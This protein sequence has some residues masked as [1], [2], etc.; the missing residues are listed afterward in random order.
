MPPTA[1]NT[2]R[3]RV[4]GPAPV[5]GPWKTRPAKAPGRRR[6]RPASIP[7]VII[8]R[9]LRPDSSPYRK[10]LAKAVGGRRRFT[11]TDSRPG[12]ASMP[13]A[14][15]GNGA[16]SGHGGHGRPARQWDGKTA[17]GR[18]GRDT[19]VRR[20]RRSQDAHVRV[21]RRFQGLRRSGST[22]PGSPA[23]THFRSVKR[24]RTGG[25]RAAGIPGGSRTAVSDDDGSGGGIP[26]ARPPP[27]IHDALRCRRER[28]HRRGSKSAGQALE[29]PARPRSARAGGGSR[30]RRREKASGAA[31][32]T[33]ASG[34]QPWP[35]TSSTVAWTRPSG[36]GGRR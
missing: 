16:S 31:T 26:V 23:R 10:R 28:R 32:G 21:R 7:P 1:R 11:L 30:Q 35:W 25:R 9:P 20:T 36:G 34:F 27:L 29:S 14:L 24:P 18:C 12:R 8:R 22:E 3:P 33:W 19:N 17:A 4:T 15:P 13:T 5:E 2:D 6:P